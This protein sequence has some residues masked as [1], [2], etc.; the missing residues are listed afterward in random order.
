MKENQPDIKHKPAEDETQVLRKQL[1]E[2][3]SFAD[4]TLV[5]LRNGNHQ[6]FQ[7]IYL[8]YK[9]SIEFFLQKL[10]GSSD[11]AKELTQS[12]FVNLWEKREMIDPQKN[13]KSF[14]FSIARNAALNFFKHQK[15]H[16][17]FVQSE[18]QNDSLDYDSDEAMVMKEAQILIE[19]AISRMPKVRRQVF[20]MSRFQELSNDE[21][22]KR[23]NI[24]K[25]T[26][27]SHI[28]NAM[29]DIKKILIIYILLVMP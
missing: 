10:L 15:V 2:K 9:E 25:D 6:A 22:A 1:L 20:E 27:Y 13:M 8:T 28:S 24:S 4:Q 5:N 7:D 26:V 19:I 12:I 11:E 17:R 29:R 3:M 16:D 18:M 14:L 21:I 23:L